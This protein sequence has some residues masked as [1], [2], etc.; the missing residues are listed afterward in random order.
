MASTPRTDYQEAFAAHQRFNREEGAES[1]CARLDNARET[2]VA[3]RALKE[4]YWRRP[5]L[6][7]AW[8]P[9]T[10]H[11]QT[12]EREINRLEGKVSLLT[13]ACRAFMGAL[14]TIE[15]VEA[16]KHK[17]PCERLEL[18]EQ[19][20]LVIKAINLAST[21][22]SSQHPF[23]DPEEAA[24]IPSEL[25]ARQRALFLECYK[26]KPSSRK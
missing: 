19:A 4:T 17:P 15:E 23:S 5:C 21:E 3:L 10:D 12:I 16:Q 9:F 11:R 24:P 1:P 6:K 22:E 18:F 7:G 8:C 25:L 13:P 2:L 26:D 14:Q 20:V